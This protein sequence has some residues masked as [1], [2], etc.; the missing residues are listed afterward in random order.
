MATLKASLLVLA[1]S[2]EHSLRKAFFL[3][4]RPIFYSGTLNT[5][6][7]LPHNV[8]NPIVLSVMENLQ[9]VDTLDGS[10]LESVSW[11]TAFTLIPGHAAINKLTHVNKTMTSLY[12]LEETQTMADA[13]G[14]NRL[15]IVECDGKYT[16]VA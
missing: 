1:S 3:S 13:R 2:P 9:V 14:K 10:R 11:D 12:A 6:A 15:T 5:R 8:G 16:T 7:I 4:S